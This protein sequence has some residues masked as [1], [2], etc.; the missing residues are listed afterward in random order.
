MTTETQTT[1]IDRD[2]VEAQIHTWFAKG[3]PEG[4]FAFSEHFGQL[5]YI[6]MPDPNGVAVW[7]SALGVT[8]VDAHGQLSTC[9]CEPLDLGGWR[10]EVWCD[11]PMVP[12]EQRVAV[13]EAS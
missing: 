7:A 9:C 2:Q 6:Q 3:L 1:A 5:V 13:R 12:Q 10:L 8:V 11:A 4:T